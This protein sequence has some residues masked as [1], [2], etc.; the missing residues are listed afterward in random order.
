MGNIWYQFMK[1]YIKLALFFYYKKIK[2]VGRENIPKNGA[3]MFV[4]NHPNA[5]IDPLL[6]K[7][8][9][10]KDLYVLT[11]AGA[12]VNKFVIAIFESVKMIPIY[13]K[14]DGY[15]SVTKND[16]VFEKCYDTLNDKKAIL[17]FAEG[18]HSLL[19]KVRPLTKGFARII[20]GSFEKYP[21]LDIQIVPI[22]V[23]YKS[24]M[25]YPDSVEIHFGKPITAKKYYNNDDILSSIESL[26]E[27][28]HNSLTELVS[29]IPGDTETYETSLAKLKSL[30]N[31]FS[32]PIKTNNLIKELDSLVA[33]TA[34]KK[35]KNTKSILYYLVYIN[36]II[37]WLFWNKVKKGIKEPEFISTFRFAVGATLFPLFY[38]IQSF[39]ASVFYG[40]TIAL[41]YF[42]LSILSSLILAKTLKVND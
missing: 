20:Y 1:Y 8:N 40:K 25:K 10:F 29:H 35:S 21:E 24:P 14:R 16:A 41:V 23:N 9:T 17:I 22:G 2:L 4:C 38:I 5:L 36:S 34:H 13:R 7:T 3:I 26:K 15:N 27:T 18:S 12:F 19:R 28:V 11:R 31:D 32:D 39:I 33:N 30:N 37:P 42:S 6:I